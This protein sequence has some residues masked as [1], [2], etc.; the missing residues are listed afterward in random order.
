[1]LSF[2]YV[3]TCR[4]VDLLIW[5]A[6]DDA[7]RE[8]GDCRAAP[9][10]R[11]DASS[12]ETRRIPSGRPAAAGCVEPGAA[13]LGVA[14]IVG[15]ARD[16]ASLASQPGSAQLDPVSGSWPSAVATGHDRAGRAARPREPPMGLPA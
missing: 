1:M 2:L 6:R 8:L 14:V 5:R 4:L 3:L 11:G 9:S 16:A 7:S 12:G 15:D 13:P 10:G